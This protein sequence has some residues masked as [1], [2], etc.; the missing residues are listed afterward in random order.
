MTAMDPLTLTHAEYGALLAA[1]GRDDASAGAFIRELERLG[2]AYQAIVGAGEPAP[3]AE[4]PTAVREDLETFVATA[5]ALVEPLYR[6][7]EDLRALLTLHYLSESTSRRALADLG[8][9]VQPLE[10][11]AGI[12]ARLLRGEFDGERRQ[13][14]DPGLVLLQ[15]AARAYRNAF[16]LRVELG[17]LPTLT[18][19]LRILLRALA[20]R[21]LVPAAR[22]LTGLDEAIEEALAASAPDSKG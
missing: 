13:L 11:L 14:E 15:A 16:N 17:A 7:P 21:G 8:A 5:G 20:E 18:A 12:A 3:G 19:A 2:R 22:L 9:V 1:L 6:L 10:D 4:L